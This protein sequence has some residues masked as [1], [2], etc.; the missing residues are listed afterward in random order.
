MPA[1]L[2]PIHKL[3][4]YLDEETANA[5]AAKVAAEGGT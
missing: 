1:Q 5:R 3:G 2:R 4:R